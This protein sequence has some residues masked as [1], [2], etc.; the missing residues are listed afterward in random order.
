ME[1]A[2]ETAKACHEQGIHS[3]AVTAG[4]I[5][6]QPRREFFRSMDAANVDLKAFTERFYHKICNAHL[7]PVL[8]TLALSAS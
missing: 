3:V 7:A 2:L 8:D 1:Y 5:N 4:Y 6:D